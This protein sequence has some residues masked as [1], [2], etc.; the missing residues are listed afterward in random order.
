ML[1]QAFYVRDGKDFRLRSLF[2]D[3]PDEAADVTRNWERYFGTAS[4]RD[5][6][7]P[8]SEFADLA[9]E[10]AKPVM[11]PQEAGRERWLRP[12]LR[13]PSS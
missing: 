4:E 13:Q 9:L 8:F 3:N 5:L 2:I 10:R 6:K 12:D 1:V 11:S 7:T